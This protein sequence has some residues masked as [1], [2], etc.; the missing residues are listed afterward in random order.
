MFITG[1]Y[2]FD[3]DSELELQMFISNKEVDF[4]DSIDN[5]LKDLISKILNKN[6]NERISLKEIIDSSFFN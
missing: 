3:S 2:P 5:N 6:P 1:K 4:P